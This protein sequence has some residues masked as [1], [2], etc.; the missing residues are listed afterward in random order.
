LTDPVKFAPSDLVELYGRRWQVE[1][2]LR[3]LKAQMDA[4]QLE[5]HS[6]S[7]ARKQ[8]LACLLAYNLIR[9]AMLCA[10]RH[11]GTGPLSL[12]FSACRR[13]LEAWLRNF[14]RTAGAPRAQWEIFLTRLAQCRLP[15][16]KRPRPA[17][18]RAKRHIRESFPPLIGSRRQARKKLP[19][20]SRKS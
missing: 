17:E 14:G 13:C 5:V 1:L 6:A 16:R 4:E 20:S 11:Q 3:Y 12:S 15:K 8:W 7:M 2:N 9:A 18:P 19:K 10:A